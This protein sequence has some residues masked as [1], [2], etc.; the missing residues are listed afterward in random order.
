MHERDAYLIIDLEL[1]RHSECS[2][3]RQD[4]S[5][6]YRQLPVSTLEGERRVTR[7]ELEGH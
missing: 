3:D 4:A 6:L 7:A 2:P 5:Q 1:C